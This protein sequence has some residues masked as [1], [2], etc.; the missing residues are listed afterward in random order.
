MTDAV[1][2]LFLFLPFHLRH[3][4]TPFVLSCACLTWCASCRRFDEP[5]AEHQAAAAVPLFPA[6]RLARCSSSFARDSSIPHAIS[7]SSMHRRSHHSPLAI[8][9]VSLVLLLIALALPH[10]RAQTQTQSPTPLI[11]A[12][13]QSLPTSFQPPHGQ[14]LDETKGDGNERSCAMTDRRS[15]SRFCCSLACV[16]CL[17]FQ[18]LLPP[19]LLPLLPL[20]LPP[21]APSVSLACVHAP[22]RWRWLR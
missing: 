1:I 3:S 12:A 21:L 19:P 15:H 14:S 7:L 16:T 13:S 18:P 8:A 20:P 22:S 10:T 4:L 17:H 11:S 5:I 2:F 6:S 9:A